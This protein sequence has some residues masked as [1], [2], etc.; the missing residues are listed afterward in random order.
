MQ[1]TAYKYNLYN[2]YTADGTTVHRCTV[3][4]NTI[5]LFLYHAPITTA[6]LA[7]RQ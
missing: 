6:N 2:T 5:K 4:A 1:Q 3:R 7:K